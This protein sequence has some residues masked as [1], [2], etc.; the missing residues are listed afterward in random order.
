M[1]KYRNAIILLIIFLVGAGGIYIMSII[2]ANGF[3]EQINSDDVRDSSTYRS[4]ESNIE[5]FKNLNNWSSEDYL[6]NMSD[7]EA[8]HKNELID[9]VV[10]ANLISLLDQA[11]E[12]KTYARTELYLKSKS[13]R[14]YKETK[15]Q[16]LFLKGN[17]T[18]SSQSSEYIRLLKRYYYFNKVL[19]EK[20]ENFISSFDNYDNDKYKALKSELNDFPGFSSRYSSQLKFQKL[21]H[22]LEQDL[23]KFSYEY[24]VYEAKRK[25]EEE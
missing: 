24:Y 14:G 2:E 18:Y 17:T 19:P 3:Q 4:L 6:T 1:N 16:L 13:S 25:Q 11:L 7:I 8:S 21:S 23:D 9:G 12:Q 5:S 22:K 10:K 20:V 15:N